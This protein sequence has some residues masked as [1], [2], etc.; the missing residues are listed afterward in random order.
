MA[1]ILCD[2]GLDLDLRLLK[3][4]TRRAVVRLLVF[5]VVLTRAAVMAPAPVLFDVPA[6]VASMMGMILVV[7]EPTV[8]GPLFDH[9]RPSDK[10]HRVLAWEGSSS[11]GTA[12]WSPPPRTG[13]SPERGTT[14][15]CRWAP[16]RTRLPDGTPGVRRGRRCSGPS[17]TGR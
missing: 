5:Q 14:P 12:G 10:V 8:V 17:A 9:A 6:A 7:S 4:A 16:Y 15:W 11:A 3:G 2:A 1:V 13:G